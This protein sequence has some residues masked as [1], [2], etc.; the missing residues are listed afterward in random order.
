[1][2]DSWR[3]ECQE[4][5]PRWFPCDSR[6]SSHMGFK[7]RKSCL[8]MLFHPKFNSNI[9]AFFPFWHKECFFCPNFF[10]ITNSCLTVCHMA[11]GQG[12]DKELRRAFGLLSRNCLLGFMGGSPAAHGRR[13][14]C[15]AQLPV[16]VALSTHRRLDMWNMPW[17]ILGHLSKQVLWPQVC[18]SSGITVSS[19]AE[20]VA[21]P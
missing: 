15:T 11:V 9:I 3:K 5:G 8:S 10:Y 19:G 13:T 2:I 21:N 7:V 14:W 16:S 20:G 4:R 17:M 18:P 1:M 12:H 6:G